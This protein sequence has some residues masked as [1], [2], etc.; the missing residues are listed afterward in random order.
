ME[1][2]G[3]I[4]GEDLWQW[5]D[6][7]CHQVSAH[8]CCPQAAKS[9]L[10]ELDWL[11]TAVIKVDRLALKLETYR[12]CPA[13]AAERS[14]SELS[15]LWQRRLEE[16]VPV[17][18]LLG[19]TTW[20]DFTLTVAPGVLIP[21]PETELL[22]DLA[23]AAAPTLANTEPIHWVDLGTGSGAI[24]LAL[25][26]CF[27]SAIIH[28][29]DASAIALDIAKRNAEQLGLI[30]RVQ[31]YQGNWLEPLAHLK[32]E[33]T[34]I[35]SNP[36]YIPSPLV[37]TLQPEVAHHEPHLALDGG[38]DG[39]DAFRAIVPQGVPFLKSGGVLLLEMMEG[40]AETVT[41]L[42]RQSGYYCNLQIHPDL[43]GIQRFAQA[44]RI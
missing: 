12:T 22:I 33:L 29:V 39:L 2:S 8:I 20:R 3:W 26:R 9:Y 13:I 42:L 10:R 1:P 19:R 18:Y 25:A 40:Q 35:V 32:G 16:N 36:P 6:S 7:A 38:T 21:R 34:G 28:A 17:Q 4:S 43:A 31:F 41:D 24:A 44:Q 37:P 14:L 5:R 11:L 15:R 23:M 27:P 30:D